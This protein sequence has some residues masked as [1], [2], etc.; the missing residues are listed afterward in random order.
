MAWVS[1]FFISNMA[2]VFFTFEHKT[3]LSGYY[4]IVNV[5]AMKDTK[6]L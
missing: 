3:D 2:R 5:T 6:D 4:E 1:V